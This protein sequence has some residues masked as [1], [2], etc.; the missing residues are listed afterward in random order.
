MIFLDAEDHVCVCENE[1]DD[2]VP[3]ELPL[4]DHGYLSCSTLSHSFPKA[5]NLKYKNETTGRYR[6][7]A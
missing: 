6:T 2:C 1:K 3:L 5:V 7:L 4:D